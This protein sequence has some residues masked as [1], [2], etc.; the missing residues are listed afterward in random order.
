MFLRKIRK[1]Q[2]IYDTVPKQRR[3]ESRASLVLRNLENAVY[4]CNVEC[5]ILTIVRTVGRTIRTLERIVLL[6]CCIVM[7][8][9]SRADRRQDNSDGGTD[10]GVVMMTCSRTDRRQDNSDVGID[11]CVATSAL[12]SQRRSWYVLNLSHP[13]VTLT[14]FPQYQVHSY[15][16]RE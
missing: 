3:T 9:R 16:Y 5:S 2:T 10:D 7:S 13:S 6:Y 1:F 15:P 8:S 14:N 4:S 11:D 12:T